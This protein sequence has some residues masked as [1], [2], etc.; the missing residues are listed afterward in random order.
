MNRPERQGP[1]RGGKAVEHDTGV[2]CLLPGPRP[3]GSVWPGQTCPAWRA[4]QGAFD[5]EPTCWFCQY[6]DFHLKTP[7]ALDVGICCWP[8]VQM[9]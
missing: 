6:A 1:A 7:V 4:R 2:R 9:E 8:E 5:D 3:G